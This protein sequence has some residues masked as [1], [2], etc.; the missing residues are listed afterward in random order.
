[1]KRERF[2]CTVRNALLR[3]IIRC[4]DLKGRLSYRHKLRAHEELMRR[5]A[6]S[7][8]PGGALPDANDKIRQHTHTHTRKE[9]KR[10]LMKG[11]QTWKGGI[12]GKADKTVA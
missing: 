11:E 4:F 10:N 9:T 1:M 2:C 3:E 12:K 5:G 8:A 7:V 6:P